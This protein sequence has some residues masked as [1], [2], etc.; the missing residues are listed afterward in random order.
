MSISHLWRY[1]SFHT[2]DDVYLNGHFICV[3]MSFIWVLQ[4]AKDNLLG[5]WSHKIIWPNVMYI[6]ILVCIS[7]YTP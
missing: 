1:V 6:I 3:I 4:S 2:T 7:N 5:P